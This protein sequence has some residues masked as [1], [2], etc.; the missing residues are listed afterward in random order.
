MATVRLR[1]DSERRSHAM[2][3]KPLDAGC[4]AAASSLH[5]SLALNFTN[6]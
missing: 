4:L 2:A 3:R 6:V 1:P 5:F